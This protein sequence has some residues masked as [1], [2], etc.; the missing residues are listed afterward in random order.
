ML[1]VVMFDAKSWLS[2]CRDSSC[3]KSFLP[4]RASIRSRSKDQ[5][6]V[7]R[8]MRAVGRVPCRAYKRLKKVEWIE[9]IWMFAAGQESV[10]AFSRSPSRPKSL[11]PPSLDSP[12]GQ[13]SVLAFSTC[14]ESL[15]AF[16]RFP[17]RPKSLFPLS[18]D[19]PP[20]QES[21][22]A[23]SRLLHLPRVSSRLL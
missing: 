16:S 17:S 14:Q 22:P 20:G 21:V 18:L 23:F 4:S 9:E 2:A 12:T 1:F 15:P 5:C 3:V 13:E 6:K 11:F 7:L 8:R 19:F 10:P